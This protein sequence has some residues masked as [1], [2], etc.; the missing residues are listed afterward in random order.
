MESGGIERLTDA[1]Q[2]NANRLLSGQI[3]DSDM[4]ERFDTICAGL[5]AAVPG[6]KWAAVTISIG[7]RLECHGA[8]DERIPELAEVMAKCGHG[9]CIDAIAAGTT[10]EILVN[11]LSE[12]SERWPVFA[13]AAVKAGMASVLCHAMAPDDRPAGS[14]SVWSDEVGAFADPLAGTI[15]AALATQAAI[16]VYGA[17]R[18]MHLTQA[19]A[20]RDLIGRAKGILMERFGLSD[21]EA[22]RLLVRT[23]Q[24]LNMKLRDVAEYL[25]QEPGARGDRP[26]RRSSP[27]E[28]AD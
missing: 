18:A 3:S 19:L 26:G 7:D 28:P 22:F 16:A 10:E 4:E 27:T 13:P 25:N 5:V 2:G 23:S 1:L 21:D 11:D 6:A 24:D 14:I 17:R 8:T 9:P 20:S 12:A 15:M